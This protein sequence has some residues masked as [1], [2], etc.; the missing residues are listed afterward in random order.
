MT[1]VKKKEIDPEILL[2]RKELDKEIRN[3]CRKNGI[4]KNGKTYT[5][6]L[7]ETLYKISDHKIELTG[8]KNNFTRYETYRD[9]GKKK[10][11]YVYIFD[12]TN[13]IVNIFTKLKNEH[14]SKLN[15]LLEKQGKDDV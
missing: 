10:I 11:K 13:D 12:N 8:T 1:K 9:S 14:I 2:A 6:K 15:K 7:G 5:F 4:T 3:F